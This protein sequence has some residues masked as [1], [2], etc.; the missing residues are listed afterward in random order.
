MFFHCLLFFFIVAFFPFCLAQN[1]GIPCPLNFTILR[2][3]LSNRPQLNPSDDCHFLVQGLRLL[4]SDYLKRTAS[5]VPPLNAS[6]SCWQS[7]QSLLPNF[8]I[9]SSCGFQTAWISQGCLNL[10]TRADFEASVPIS[11]LNDVASNCNQSLGGSACA[12][13]TR[14]L[15]SLQVLHN[16]NNSIA[17]VSDCTAYPFI[18]AAAVANYLGPTDEVTATCLFSIDLSDNSNGGGKNWGVII[19]VGVGL[20]VFIL[21]SWFLYRKHRDSRRDRIR[22]LEMG[23]LVDYGSGMISESSNL[24]KFTFDEIKKATRNFS[25]DN[26]IGRGGYGN[27]Y[28]GYLSD[29]SEVALKRFKNCSAAGD[30]NFKHEVE[31]IASV[32]HVNL[33]ALRGYCT[34][35]TPSEGHQ[36]IIVCDLMKNGSLYDHLFGPTKARLSWPIRQKIALG[37]ARGLAYLHHGAQPM[38]IHRDIKASNILL[39]DMFEAKVADFGLAK[40]APEGMTHLSTRVAGT[41]GYVAPEYALYGQLTDRSDVYSFGVVLLELLSGKKALTVNNENQPCVV[42]DW[43]WS[44]VKNEKALDVIEDGMPELGPREVL[45]KYVLIALLCSHPELQCRPSMDQVVKMLETDVSVPSIPER[46]IS[47]VADIDDIEIFRR[48]SDGLA[49]LHYGRIIHRDIKASN[50]LLDDIFEAKVADFGLAKFTPEGMTHLSTRVTGTTGYVA[51]EY[52]LYGQLTDRSDVYSFG[53]VLLEL[54]SGKK[55]LTVNDENQPSVAADWAWSFGE[56]RESFRRRHAGVGATRSYGEIRF[57]SSSSRVSMPA[58][59]GSGSEYIGNRCFGS[60]DP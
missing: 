28:K 34:A 20:A 48:L 31:V 9:R 45:E 60:L 1:G 58:I 18:Y 30:A 40:F 53:V 25:I 47:L 3:A 16:A 2:P 11:T 15:A 50:I 38:I 43:A 26:I 55:A 4:L 51:P 35:T 52:A 32:R 12:S 7:Y 23:R 8:D 42:A 13:C 5:F 33:V 57:Y 41:M 49:Y 54:L 22:N 44:L 56:E 24:V 29:G 6:H 14:S 19:G 59:Y 37:M 36:R 46:P 10:T 27:V 17:N 39:D 21:L